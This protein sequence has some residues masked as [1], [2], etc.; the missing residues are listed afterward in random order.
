MYDVYGEEGLQAGLQVSTFVQDRQDLHHE[1]QSFKNKQVAK[2]IPLTST[3][4]HFDAI[5]DST[6]MMAVSF[7]VD[8]CPSLPDFCQIID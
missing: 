2:T 7:S 1:W 4:G 6:M 3:G 8:I 5:F